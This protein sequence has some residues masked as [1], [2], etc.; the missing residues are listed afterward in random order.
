MVKLMSQA[1]ISAEPCVQNEPRLAEELSTTSLPLGS[2]YR[3]LGEKISHIGCWG[4]ENHSKHAAVGA[5]GDFDQPRRR[6][7]PRRLLRAPPRRA[8]RGSVFL[9]DV[10]RTPFVPT[11]SHSNQP[12][13][14]FAVESAA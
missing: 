14:R 7:S 1:D 11:C 2:P 13:A 3:A 6:R 8:S 10:G 12:P 5:A 4:A 9:V